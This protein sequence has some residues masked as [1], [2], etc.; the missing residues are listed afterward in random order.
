[1]KD[2]HLHSSKKY[3]DMLI[4]AWEVC[5]KVRVKYSNMPL[6][7]N[8]QPS[9]YNVDTLIAALKNLLISCFQVGNYYTIQVVQA[10]LLLTNSCSYSRFW[11][12]HKFSQFTPSLLVSMVGTWCRTNYWAISKLFQAKLLMSRTIWFNVSFLLVK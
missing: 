7:L 11:Y 2:M 3:K 1:M 10:I 12:Y 5:K 6:E 9:A 8:T 4:F